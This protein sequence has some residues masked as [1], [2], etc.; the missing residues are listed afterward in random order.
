[1]TWA[2]FHAESEKFASAAELAA[3]QGD[4]AAAH[5]LYRQ[6]ADAEVRALV[7]L[8][9]K[10]TRTLGITAVSAVA[11][12]YKAHEFT[13][14]E[15]LAHKWLATDLLPAFSVEQL[16]TLLQMMWND[17][18]RE[19]AGVKFTGGEVLI[20]VK[21][22]ETVTGGAPLELIVRK[23]EEVRNIFYR[24]AEMLL[25]VPHRKR[26]PASAEIQDTFRPWLFQAAPGSYQFAVCV[27][28][29][30]QM[31][32]FP[33]AKIEAEKVAAKFIE[34]VKASIEDPEGALP[35]VVPDPD[36]RKTFLRMTRNLAPTGDDFGR[37]E[38]RPSTSPT[39]RPI[40]LLPGA[41]E[42]IGQTLRKQAPSAPPGAPQHD[43]VQL[44]GVLRGLQL[45]KDW[46][47]VTVEGQ[48]VRIT[49][50]GDQ[51]DDV[52]GPMVNRRVIVD[53]Y[54]TKQGKMVLRDIKPAG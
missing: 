5:D 40:V 44:T 47:E 17:V 25:A 49:G 38:V 23:V 8:D 35:E 12:S 54:R 20:S 27:Q 4:V 15:R 16:Q 3:K 50:A 1:M 41:R 39:A 37:L 26:G 46:I 45:D 29:P 2:E 7:A 30:P 11:L 52:L 6:A 48:T 21:G 53:A 24:T 22:G 9:V 31:E 19:K 34:I 43:E 14:A 36:Y 42:A 33:K 32:L 28:E 51:V 18:V 13:Q 10:K